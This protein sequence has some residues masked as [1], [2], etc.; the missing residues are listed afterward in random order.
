MRTTFYL[1]LIF[2]S[3]RRTPRPIAVLLFDSELD[4]LH[5][6]FREDW[7]LIADPEDVE[8]LGCLA[9][10]FAQKVLDYSP[11]AFLTYLEDTLSNVL[12]LTERSPVAI[13][14]VDEAVDMLFNSLVSGR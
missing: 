9:E 14:N 4:S 6:R 8:F 5:W 3:P 1:L 10:D 12:Q 11:G 7:E 13:E 2:A